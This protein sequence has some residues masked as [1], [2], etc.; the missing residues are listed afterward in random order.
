MY[1]AGY[2]KHMLADDEAMGFQL[3][4]KAREGS[5][6]INK[7]NGN[8]KSRFPVDLIIQDV[9]FPKQT[10]INYKPQVKN[11]RVSPGQE[12]PIAFA[13]EVA[14]EE[15]DFTNKY[16]NSNEFMLVNTLGTQVSV[17]LRY[18][19]LGLMCGLHNA[20]TLS[21]EK[22]KPVEGIAFGYVAVGQRK[23]I[24]MD[25]LNPTMVNYIIKR[26]EFKEKNSDVEIVFENQSK[27]GMKSYYKKAN[28]N[29]NTFF[30]IP[31]NEVVSIRIKVKPKYTGNF[32]DSVTIYFGKG[33]ITLQVS[34]S[35][36]NGGLEFSPS[37]LKYDLFYPIE[38][39][40]QQVAV[41]NNFNANIEITT[42]WSPQSFIFTNVY[43]SIVDAKSKTPFMG[44]T[45]DL[46]PDELMDS[47]RPNYLRP[48]HSKPLPALSDLIRHQDQVAGWERLVKERQTEVTGEVIVQT[49]LMADLKIP[50]KA[51]LRKASIVPRDVL[52]LGPIEEQRLH[53]INVTL[54]NPT[55][56]N[57]TMRFFLADAQM[58]DADSLK[59]RVERRLKKRYAKFKDEIVCVMQKHLSEEDIRYF[60][61]VIFG[62]VKH[63]PRLKSS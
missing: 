17:L 56:R 18:Y 34:Y 62:G 40:E 11:R 10:K 36:I 52:T 41:V 6:I 4:R 3:T 37:P 60:M 48:L 24:T 61:D 47:R 42:A 38:S 2:Y 7:F 58:L 57:V 20:I 23:V 16:S 49:E 39:D 12:V 29:L 46:S 35:G 14:H 22:C 43:G 26:V 1:Y 25:I 53:T 54:S 33:E 50:V 21:Y 32:R 9:V 30:L 59:A 15:S 63:V 19:S 5:R 31:K 8:W 13:A 28:R 45:I 55:N 51:T 27:T 44:V